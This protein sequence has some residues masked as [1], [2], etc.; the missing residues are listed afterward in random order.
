MYQPP[1]FREERLETLHSFIRAHTLATLI[2]AGSGGL[3]A[4]LVPFTLLNG[5]EKGTLRAH[6]A[7]A[8]DQV[9]TYLRWPPGCAPVPAP[10]RIATT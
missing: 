6:V 10:L 7:K 2:T 3:L 1:V 8:N 9:D 4:N 5:G